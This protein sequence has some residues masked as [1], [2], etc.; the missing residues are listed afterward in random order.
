VA[1]AQGS[2]RIEL[3]KGVRS[4]AVRLIV[5]SGTVDDHTQE[6]VTSACPVEELA[7]AKVDLPENSARRKRTSPETWHG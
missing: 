5:R 2:R 1:V 3:L 6:R 4:H 7:W